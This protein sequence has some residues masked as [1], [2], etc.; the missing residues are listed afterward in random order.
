MFD[1]LSLSYYAASL[2]EWS[3]PPAEPNSQ[4]DVAVIGGGFTGLSAALALA[5]VMFHVKHNLKPEF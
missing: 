3:P 5:D 2:N 4:Y 1:P